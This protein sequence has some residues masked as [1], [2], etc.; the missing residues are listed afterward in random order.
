MGAKAEAINAARSE[1]RAP[2]PSGAL[3]A[4]PVP[5]R[6]GPATSTRPVASAADIDGDGQLDL[7]L[8]GG[9]GGRSQVLLR[10]GDRFEAH[11]EHPLA[12]FRRR[13]IRRLGRYR[14]TTV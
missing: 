11:P 12:R 14:Q 13:R 5:L 4:E 3:F 8:P 10:V 2:A 6:A 1:S 9:R 7:F